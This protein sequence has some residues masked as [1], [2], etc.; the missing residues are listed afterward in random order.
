[1]PPSSRGWGRSLDASALLLGSPDDDR[2]M[3]PFSWEELWRFTGR[4][5]SGARVGE[6]RATG[7]PIGLSS[8]KEWR[9]GARSSPIL[10]SAGPGLLM[11]IAFLDPGNL[12]G[13]LQAGASGGFRLLWVLLWS[14]VMGLLLQMQAARIGVATGQDLAACCRDV[15]PRVPRC[16]ALLAA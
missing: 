11:S 7:V 12:E 5:A 13:D 16:A 10:V 9:K 15:Y 1:M 3:S 4:E 14:H 2:S 8:R 6:R